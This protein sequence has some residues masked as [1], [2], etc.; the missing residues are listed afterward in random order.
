MMTQTIVLCAVICQI[1]KGAGLDEIVR[2]ADAAIQADWASFPAYSYIQRDERASGT[3]SITASFQ[4]VVIEGSDYHLPVAIGDVP[5][6]ESQRQ[7][8]IRKLID[9]MRQRRAESPAARASRISAYQHQ[10]DENNAMV[11]GLHDAFSFRLIGEEMADSH[12]AW[13]LQADPRRLSGSASRA[14]KVLS[15][16][17]GMV[18]IEQ[19]QFHTIRAVCTVKSPISLFGLFARV[20]PGSQMEFRMS[21]VNDSVWLLNELT[22]TLVV[23]KVFL[24]RRTETIRTVYSGYRSNPAVLAELLALADQ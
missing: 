14:I 19:Q 7:A 3:N 6:S 22:T 24:F 20:M 8:E 4:V 11:R 16:M 2:R 15:G 12:A 17:Y 10:L 21:P 1:C 5:L 18:W 13:V 23:S 9:E